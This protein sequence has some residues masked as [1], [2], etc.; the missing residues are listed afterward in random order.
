MQS[1]LMALFFLVGEINIFIYFYKSAVVAFNTTIVLSQH[2]VF[3][4]GFLL[5]ICFRGVSMARVASNLPQQA[6]LLF[7]FFI[8]NSGEQNFELS[9]CL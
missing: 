4:V 6:G 2:R 3:I 1:L 5:L 7:I 8:K 9:E